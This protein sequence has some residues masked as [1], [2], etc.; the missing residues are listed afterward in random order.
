[1]E[2]ARAAAAQPDSTPAPQVNSKF[3]RRLFT[4]VSHF[5]SARTL[6]KHVLTLPKGPGSIVKFYLLSGEA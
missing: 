6:K 1:M 5:T 2:M 3:R 4:F